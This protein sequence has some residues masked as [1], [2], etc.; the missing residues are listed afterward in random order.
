MPGNSLVFNKIKKNIVIRLKL[1]RWKCFKIKLEF[2]FKRY[3]YNCIHNIIM[4]NPPE[5]NR[6]QLI[7][8]ALRETA[9]ENNSVS[10]E[11]RKQ[12]YFQ[13]FSLL[14]IY[15]LFQIVGRRTRYGCEI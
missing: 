2:E 4:S 14:Y 8:E 1:S 6:T 15:F 12:K 9:R 3:K 5:E 13:R 10:K 7:L 11:R